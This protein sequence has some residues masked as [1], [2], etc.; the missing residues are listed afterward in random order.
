[1]P[2]GACSPAVL[3]SS[4]RSIDR[5]DLVVDPAGL[6]ICEVLVAGQLVAATVVPDADPDRCEEQAGDRCGHAD[7]GHRLGSG[8][9][10]RGEG[11]AQA[12]RPS[13]GLQHG[14]APQ[15]PRKFSSTSTTGITKAMP[16]ASIVL[17]SRLRYSLYGMIWEVDPC[18][19]VKLISTGTSW[20]TAQ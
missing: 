20:V 9:H 6:V 16:K 1:G 3:L 19:G 13:P 10:H 5:F 17:I 2:P 4:L 14:S 12:D 18:V 11:E 7:Q 15:D 8:E